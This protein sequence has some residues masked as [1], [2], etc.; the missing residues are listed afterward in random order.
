MESV[1]IGP[2]VATET[3]AIGG[4]GGGEMLIVSRRAA[5]A[6]RPVALTVNV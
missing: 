4:A 5:N 3:V 6:V 1:A 2:E